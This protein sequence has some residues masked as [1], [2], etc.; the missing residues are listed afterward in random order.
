MQFDALEIEPQVS[1]GTSPEM[2][3]GI[4]GKVPDPSGVPNESKKIGMINALEY[5]ALKPGQ[6]ISDIA[7][8]KVFIGSCT[9]S[10]IEDLRAASEVVKGR[11]KSGGVS[12]AIVVPGSGLVKQQAEQDGAKKLLKYKNIN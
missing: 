4:S 6:K 9:N 5:M 8:D 3:V 7:V 11:K 10:R 2:V 12:L 1:W